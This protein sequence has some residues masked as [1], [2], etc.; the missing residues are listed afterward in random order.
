ME[1]KLEDYQIRL[2]D[3]DRQV[4]SS[5]CS[6]C[7]CLSASLG[8]AYEIVV[9]SL[10]IDDR[11]ILKI[12]NGEYSNRSESDGPDHKSVIE[13]EQLYV[14][15][16]HDDPP[17]NIYFRTDANGNPIKSSSIGILRGKRRLIGMLCINL[18]LNTPFSVILENLTLPK[19][20]ISEN[21]LYTNDNG[22]GYEA[23]LY[24]TITSTKQ[25]VMNDPEIPSKFKR[26]EIVR[27]LNEIGVF[28]VKNGVT[29][30]SELL[31]ITITTIYMHIRN[32]DTSNEEKQP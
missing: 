8:N 25:T 29:M 19:F 7:D 18:Y 10:G 4:L 15:A 6:L 5:Y 2:N 28:N 1:K 9:H 14:M 13:L 21:S 16:M 27:K 30:C 11:F 3:I 24:E 26:K 31:G 17:I 12:A 23:G 22:H 32:L 20:L